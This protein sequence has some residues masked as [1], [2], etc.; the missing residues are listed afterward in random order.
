MFNKIDK[1]P[2]KN[3]EERYFGE[4][5]Y[6]ITPSYLQSIHSKINSIDLPFF[7]YVICGG[8]ATL[9]DWSAFY[10]ASYIVGLSY[11]YAV[12]LS[13]TIG[14]FINYT[15]NKINTFKNKHKSIFVQ[16]SVYLS[17]ALTALLITCC[18]MIVFIEYFHFHPMV[19]RIIIT[20][21][22][23]FYNYLFHKLFT[24]GK[25]Q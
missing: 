6:E 5:P 17:G 13:F 2:K 21:N 1:S 20:G 12:I 11:L 4:Y 24:F 19:S 22:M 18:Q 7:F 25:L 8:L 23:L 16:F 9:F 15:L 3:Y 10:I 14:S